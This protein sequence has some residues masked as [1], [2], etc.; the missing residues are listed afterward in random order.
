MKLAANDVIWY[1]MLFVYWSW[2]S[3]PWQWS[4]D[5]YKSKEET[6][7]KGE[8]I[9]KTIQKHEIHKIKFQ[10]KHKEFDVR[11]PVHR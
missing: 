1:D 11:L 4:V 6:T 8:T 3:T 2:V 7:K 9:H 10:N 5:M